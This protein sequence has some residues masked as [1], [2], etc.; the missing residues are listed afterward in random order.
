MTAQFEELLFHIEEG[1]A[2]LKLNR[3]T[4]LN[5][6]GVRMAAELQAAL[7]D[8]EASGAVRVLILTGVGERA[9]CTGADLKERT[10]MDEAARWAHNRALF[11]CTNQLARLPI[12]TIA[13][14]NGLALG[15]GCE[16]T[17]ACDLR[18]AAAHAAFALPETH[19][20]IIPGAGGT[21]RLPRLIGPGRAKELIF[22]ARRIDAA[23]ALTWGLLSQVVPGDT[24]LTSA[25][26]L[27][28][29]IARQSQTALALA[30]AAIDNGLEGSLEQGL[31]HET[32][33]F[34][35]ALAAPDY[36]HRL[37]A[38]ADKKRRIVKR[39]A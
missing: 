34:R 20:G 17:L 36:Q 22:S 1:I 32:E 29:E 4:R 14:V 25:T 10:V 3:P 27:A 13:A 8:L 9:F 7:A 39:E 2:T 31:R 15:G 38:F 35:A 26:A 28:T 23:T 33:A 19:L 11:D 12:P 21:Q 5:A 24:L 18:I 6:I 16:L 30:K 37:A